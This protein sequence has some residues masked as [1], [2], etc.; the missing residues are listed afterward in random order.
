MTLEQGVCTAYSASSSANQ[1]EQGKWESG[2]VIIESND[3]DVHSYVHS[4][5][6]T[7]YMEQHTFL[8]SNDTLRA[9]RVEQHISIQILGVSVSA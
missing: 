9:E 6:T 8:S 4:H 7:A 2:K 1:W 5:N 3:I